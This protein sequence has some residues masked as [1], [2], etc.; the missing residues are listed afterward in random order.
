V[1]KL[2]FERSRILQLRERCYLTTRH[3]E[4]LHESLEWKN[5][6]SAILYAGKKTVQNTL[7]HHLIFLA[8]DNRQINRYFSVESGFLIREEQIYET[9]E[10]AQILISEI[11]DYVAEKNGTT[12]SRS[13]LNHFGTE[14]S[15]E[16]KIESVEANALD[17]HSIFAVPDSVLKLREQT[18]E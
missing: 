4:T 18:E 14:Y 1:A 2:H 3:Y 11:G 7:S 10:H 8:S 15:V 13:R 9:D 12:V 16:Y 6:Y 5:Q 17:D